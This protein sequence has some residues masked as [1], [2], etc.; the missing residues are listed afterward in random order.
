MN[1]FYCRRVLAFTLLLAAGSVGCKKSAPQHTSGT[2]ATASNSGSGSGSGSNGTAMHAGDG[3]ATGSN[4]GSGDGSGSAA[5]SATD[6]TATDDPDDE[7]NPRFKAALALLKDEAVGGIRMDMTDQEVIAVL[8]QPSK[9]GTPMEE[10]ATGETVAQWEWKKTGINVLFTDA[11]KTPKV[12]GIGLTDP[13][14]LKTKK[15]IGIGSSRAEL[16]TA[17]GAGQMKSGDD[18]ADASYTVGNHYYGLVFSFEGG[19]VKSAY[20]GVLAE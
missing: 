9:K 11:N 6:T 13:S 16:D 19:K 14:T 1:F 12:R 2:A 15:G 10:G 3:S 4:T 17:Y 20:W 8:G 18:G 7:N 5:G